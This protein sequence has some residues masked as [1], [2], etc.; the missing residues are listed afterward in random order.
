MDTFDKRNMGMGSAFVRG[1]DVQIVN[2]TPKV[3]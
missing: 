1:E 2:I 3:A